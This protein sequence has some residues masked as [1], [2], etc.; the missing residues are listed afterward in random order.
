MRRIEREQMPQ[1]RERGDSGSPTVFTAAERAW[2]RSL[3][4]G[5]VS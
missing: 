4:R 2:F 3:S 1:A 5:I